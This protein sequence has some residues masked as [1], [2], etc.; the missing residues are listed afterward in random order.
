M[1][2]NYFA[3]QFRRNVT[4]KGYDAYLLMNLILSVKI[5]LEVSNKNLS[6]ISFYKKAGFKVNRIRKNLSNGWDVLEIFLNF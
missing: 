6:A 4:S 1:H 2:D 5:L 3:H